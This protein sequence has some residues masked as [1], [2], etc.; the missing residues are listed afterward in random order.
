MVE[1]VLCISDRPT[2]TCVVLA[3]CGVF[4]CKRSVPPDPGVNECLLSVHFVEHSFFS[5]NQWVLWCRLYAY[6]ACDDCV[7]GLIGCC[8]LWSLAIG[9]ILLVR[10]MWLYVQCYGLQST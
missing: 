4:V 1:I 6:A 10:G 8:N 2:C 5:G 7:A 3:G 9:N